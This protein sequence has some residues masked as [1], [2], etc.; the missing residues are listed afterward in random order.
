MKHSSKL[1]RIMWLNVIMIYL[2]RSF[3]S[4]TVTFKFMAP[5]PWPTFH[6]TLM[7]LDCEVTMVFERI[8]RAAAVSVR[9]GCIISLGP[10]PFWLQLHRNSRAKPAPFSPHPIGS[11]ETLHFP[12]LRFRHMAADLI[13]STTL[14]QNT[15]KTRVCWGRGRD[16]NE[17]LRRVS[18][19][20]HVKFTTRDTSPVSG[21]YIKTH[22]HCQSPVH[23]SCSPLEPAS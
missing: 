19:A 7:Q 21:N 20:W 23:A 8:N 13:L 10:F 18:A 16:D 15:R 4:L 17:K 14:H 22:S 5:F 2:L 3:R 9:Q 1:T 11:A 6:C 12:Q